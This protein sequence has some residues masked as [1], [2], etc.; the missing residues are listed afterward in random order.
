MFTFLENP[1]HLYCYFVTKELWGGERKTTPNSGNIPDI[2]TDTS[3][4]YSNKKFWISHKKFK[5]KRLLRMKVTF[6]PFLCL[7]LAL[8][9]GMSSWPAL[10]IFQRCC[11]P[12]HPRTPLRHTPPINRCTSLS[13]PWQCRGRPDSKGG[14][15]RSL[16]RWPPESP[17]PNRGIAPAL[18]Q[19]P[20]QTP[21]GLLFAEGTDNPSASVA[22]PASPS[23][24]Q[25][26]CS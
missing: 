21:S 19:L 1:F 26:A 17:S 14:R 12:W 18:T 4:Q 3:L 15:W 10:G 23:T 22:G 8:S 13:F 20:S 7:P 5:P 16:G 9:Y 6:M 11:C 2:D 25:P 24:S